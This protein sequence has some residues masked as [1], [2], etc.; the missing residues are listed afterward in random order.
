MTRTLNEVIKGL[1]LDQQQEI[2]AQATRLIEEEMTLRDLR[3][4]HE[5]TQETLAETLGISQDGVSRIE[6]RSD[7]LLSTLRSYVGAMGGKLRLIAEFP[8][9]KPVILSDL[10][11]LDT[12]AGRDR[13]TPS[14]RAGGKQSGRP[15]KKPRSVGVT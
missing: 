1:P 12:H 11:S 8:D 5:L 6:K 2:E 7:F 10:K 3:K 15:K 14:S 4:A 9:R 13:K